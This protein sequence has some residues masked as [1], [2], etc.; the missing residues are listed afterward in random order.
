MNVFQPGPKSRAGVLPKAVE[1]GGVE[2]VLS[3]ILIESMERYVS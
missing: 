1:P 3:E 2:T